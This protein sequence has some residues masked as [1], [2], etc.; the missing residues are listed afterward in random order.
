MLHTAIADSVL[1]PNLADTQRNTVDA[2][3]GSAASGTRPFAEVVFHQ[4]CPEM[5]TCLVVA[6]EWRQVVAADWLRQ[7]YGPHATALQL[8][9]VPCQALQPAHVLCRFGLDF[10]L[11]TRWLGT[12]GGL[13]GAGGSG[14][15]GGGFAGGGGGRGGVDQKLAWAPAAAA[16]ADGLLM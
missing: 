2:W 6:V 12:A 15:G 14:L 4:N 3:A 7:W 10:D 13:G 1:D 11:D 5:A 8:D 9:W 16:P